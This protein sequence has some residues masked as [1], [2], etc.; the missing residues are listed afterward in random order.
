MTGTS[1]ELP[2]I[3]R[4]QVVVI[5][6]GISGLSAAYALHQANIDFLV[7][8]SRSRAGGV[9]ETTYLDDCLVEGGPDSY[10]SQKPWATSLI[11]KLGMEHELIGSND[12]RRRTYIVRNGKLVPMPDGLLMMIPTKVMPMLGTKLLSWSTK[13]RMGLELFRGK[14]P[15]PRQADVS[16]AD[17][18]RDHYGQEAVDYLAEPL[19]A[20]VY[21]GDPE[22][23][24]ARSVLGRFVDLESKYGSLC[25]GVLRERK[26]ARKGHPPGA[27]FRSL[28]NGMGS[29]VERLVTE[30]GT[31]RFR[32]GSPVTKL[33]R[34]PAYYA[35]HLGQETVL[36]SHVIVATPAY[37]AAA[38]L[39][40]INPAVASRLDQIP[41]NSSATVA[42]TYKCSQFQQLPQGFGFL[43]PK[44]ERQTLVAATYVQNKFPHRTPEDKVLLRCFVGRAAEDDERLRDDAHLLQA[45]RDDIQ[46]L[47]GLQA[48]PRA[49][50]IFRWSRAMAQYEV[51]HSALISEI[52]RSLENTPNLH[53]AGNAF[54]G[55]GIPDCV[56]LG[57]QCAATCVDD[58]QQTS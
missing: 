30:L 36:A 54:D 6:A 27:L 47:I 46:R 41:Y 14:P 57:E 44:R 32:L 38:L 55:I 25:R 21:G 20:G 40:Q 49:H 2:P 26:S 9:M 17:F 10:L 35:V 19:L 1:Q 45:V 34:Q 16:V 56:R 5:G 37:A 53:L 11:R 51:G 33:Q 50:A 42:L 58:L 31:K 12:D 43:V 18:F 15:S 3:T 13:F 52:R 23:M 24:S 7:V 22:R 8:D 48:T 39:K 29:L 4:R 28:R